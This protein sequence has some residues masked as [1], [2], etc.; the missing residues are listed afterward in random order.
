VLNEA[1]FGVL[2]TEGPEAAAAVA[3]K[4]SAEPAADPEPA[5][6]AEPAAD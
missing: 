4:P 5:A 2:L 1:G 6:G 3:E